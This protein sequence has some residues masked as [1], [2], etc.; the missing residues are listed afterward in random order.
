MNTDVQIL[1][2]Y[3]EVY[4]ITLIIISSKRKYWKFE[5]YSVQKNS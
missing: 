2:T 3:F 4:V 5:V 1:W